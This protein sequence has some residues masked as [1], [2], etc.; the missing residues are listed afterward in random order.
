MGIQ[1]RET[2][3][4]LV[5][6]LIWLNFPLKDRQNINFFSLF[7]AYEWQQSLPVHHWQAFTL[8]LSHCQ[9]PR[10]AKKW[11]L[12]SYIPEGAT[13]QHVIR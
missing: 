8:W 3:S 12:E 9:T 6:D 10:A 7:A 5:I 4:T 2:E 13:G 1:G 11:M